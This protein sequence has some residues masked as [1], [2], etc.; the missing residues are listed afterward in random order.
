[1][2]D[3]DSVLEDVLQRQCRVLS[4]SQATAAGITS[5]TIKANLRAGRWQRILPRIYAT[6]TGPVPRM[7]LLWAV[8]L[9]AGRGAVL[10]HQTAAELN[11]L[12]DRPSSAIHVTVPA[13]RRPSPIPG[14]V[15]HHSERAT[16]AVHPG[17]V[18]PRTRVEE[19]VVDLTQTARTTEEAIGWI[20]SACGRRLTT[21]DRLRQALRA[22]TRLRWRQLLT[23]VVD[24][25]GSGCH[26]VLERRYLRDVERA[27]GLPHGRRQAARKTE[28]GNRYEDV[29]YDDYAV[30]TELDGRAAHP[31]ER[32]RLDQRRD[33][34]AAATGTRVLRYGWLDVD[35]PCATALQTARA[36]RAG[37]W[38]GVPTRCRRAA[39]IMRKTFGRRNARKFTGS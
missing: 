30:V 1:V 3:A 22:R 29:R 7:A 10:S 5:D 12:L 28:A 36:L 21:A 17:P 4:R 9:R 39:C 13:E 38:T 34:E 25:T 37:G 15:I 19:T 14:V 33:N 27:H 6:F 2:L 31:E 24:D 26:S 32:R 35:R 16:S 18:L 8:V 11:G 23:A 20:A